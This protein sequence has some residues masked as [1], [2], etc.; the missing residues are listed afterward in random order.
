MCRFFTN[1]TVPKGLTSSRDVWELPFR[2]PL[3]A[4]GPDEGPRNMSMFFYGGKCRWARRGPSQH[5]HVFYGGKCRWARR[6]PSPR[7]G[8]TTAAAAAGPVPSASASASALACPSMSPD[9]TCSAAGPL[10]HCM[11]VVGCLLRQ[12]SGSTKR[13]A[14]AAQNSLAMASNY[15]KAFLR[16]DGLHCSVLECERASVEIFD[17]EISLLPR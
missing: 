5:V 13:Q 12:Q 8:P 11:A 6:G 17:M 14:T 7:F 3:S 9:G 16:D 10:V 4:D 2:R 15:R 1:L